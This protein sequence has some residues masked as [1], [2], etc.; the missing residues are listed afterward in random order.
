MIADSLLGF[1]IESGNHIIEIK[2]QNNLMIVGSIISIT[3][4]L[5]I[6]CIQKKEM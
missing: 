4:L 2:Y 1:D 5:V 6:L 3:T